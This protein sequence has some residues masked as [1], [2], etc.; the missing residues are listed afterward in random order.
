MP[1]W[2]TDVALVA[3]LLAIAELMYRAGRAVRG[4]A[5]DHVRAQTTAA[6]AS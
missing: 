5:D 4:R 3:S 6:Q 1:L 2:F